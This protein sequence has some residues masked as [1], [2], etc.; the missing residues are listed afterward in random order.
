MAFSFNKNHFNMKPTAERR[1]FNF[2]M[3]FECGQ[4]HV[5]THLRELSE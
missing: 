1:E 5:I 4:V 2:E 3:V